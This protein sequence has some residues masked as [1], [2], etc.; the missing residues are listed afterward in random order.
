MYIQYVLPDGRETKRREEA[1]RAW[2]DKMLRNLPLSDYPI[3]EDVRIYIEM[4]VDCYLGALEER[5]GKW[6]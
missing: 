3:G 5:L 6:E 1:M 2:I 4:A